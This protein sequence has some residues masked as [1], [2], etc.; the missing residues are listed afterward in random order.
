[1]QKLSKQT[2]DRRNGF[3]ILCLHDLS[4]DSRVGNQSCYTLSL[5]IHLCSDGVP[6]SD[7]KEK[8]NKMNKVKKNHT[9]LLQ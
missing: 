2:R 3:E 1:M 4:F 5:L 8:N 9:H 7:R 6:T